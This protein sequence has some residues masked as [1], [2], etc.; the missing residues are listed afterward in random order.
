MIPRNYLIDRGGKIVFQSIEYSLQ[1]FDQLNIVLTE[2]P[3]SENR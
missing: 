2:L 1:E 3:S